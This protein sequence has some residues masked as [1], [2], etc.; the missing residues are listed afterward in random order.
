MRIRP[1]R[2]E[3]CKALAELFC[4]TVHSVNARDCTPEQLN[5]WATGRVDLRAWDRSLSENSTVVA[6]EAGVIAGFGDIERSGYLNR[7]YVDRDCQRRGVAA[8]ICDALE[9]AA[10]GKI[11]THASIT[12]RPFFEKRGYRVVSEQQVERGGVL[13]TRCAMEK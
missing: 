9:A 13:L 7:L 11:T 8:A 10:G 2:C 3:D 1:Y 12:A 5:A 4:R 6:V